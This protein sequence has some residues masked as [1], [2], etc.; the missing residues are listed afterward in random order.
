MCLHL[1]SRKF[2]GQYL[3]KNNRCRMRFQKYQCHNDGQHWV[4][5]RIN[6]PRPFGNKILVLRVM[7][8][9]NSCLFRAFGTAVLPGDDLSMPELR[10]LVAQTIQD[11]PDVYSKVVLDQDPDKYCRWIQTADAWGGAI[12]LGILSKHF[13]IEI[14][15]IDVQVIL[16]PWFITLAAKLTDESLFV[17]INST[18]AGLRVAF[19]YIQASTMIQSSNLHPSHHTRKLT[20]PLSSISECGIQT[21]MRF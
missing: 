19:L 13:D 6:Y 3:C 17:W 11:Q 5:S 14:C 21:M 15:S 7:P 20:P 16:R 4:S 18:R 1:E 9:D 2:L 12:E 8:D 10:S